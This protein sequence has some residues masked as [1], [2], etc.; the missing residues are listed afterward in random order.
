VAT[1][2]IAAQSASAKAEERDESGAGKETDT[3]PRVL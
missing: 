1:R 3:D 2:Q